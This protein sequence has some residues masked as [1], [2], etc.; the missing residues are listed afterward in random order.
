MGWLAWVIVLLLG[1][2]VVFI[3]TEI[4]V[5]IH[6]KHVQKDDQM[7]LKVSAWHGLLR[8]RFRVPVLEKKEGEPAIIM[9]SESGVEGNEINEETKKLTPADFQ[10]VWS[11]VRTLLEEFIGLH[12]I[13]RRFLAH[14]HL[15]RLKW[16]SMIGAGQAAHTGM[17]VGGCWALKGSI[18]GI[19]SAYLRVDKRPDCLITPDFNGY[20]AATVFSC[21]LTF[22]LIRAIGTLMILS[23]HWKSNKTKRKS[24]AIPGNTEQSI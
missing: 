9:E 2:G 18:M 13:L 7:E 4:R 22:K 3:L 8:Y 14:V 19:L 10:K 1:A 15:K 23:R 11:E 16:H 6:F 21:T 5:D 24:A 20:K 17:L 12:R